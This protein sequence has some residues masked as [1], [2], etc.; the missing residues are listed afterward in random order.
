[1]YVQFTV[2]AMVDMSRVFAVVRLAGKG[3]NATCPSQNAKS[4]IATTK[5]Y[6]SMV[7]ASAVQGIKDI[8]ARKVSFIQPSLSL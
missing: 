8:T 5:E 6:A 2:L 3:Q 4:S 1:M 7:N